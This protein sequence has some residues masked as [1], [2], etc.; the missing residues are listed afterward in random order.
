MAN[1]NQTGDDAAFLAEIRQRIDEENILRA[2]VDQ[3]NR[4]LNETLARLRNAEARS[5]LV[6]DE[7][8]SVQQ[9]YEETSNFVRVLQQRAAEADIVAQEAIRRATATGG[10]AAEQRAQQALLA[11]QQAQAR[12]AEAEARAES[13]AAQLD[14]L[15]QQFQ[16]NQTQSARSRQQVDELNREMATLREQLVALSRSI[17][18]STR[19]ATNLARNAV[20]STSRVPRGLFTELASVQAQ[21]NADALAY[22]LAYARNALLAGDGLLFLYEQGDYAAFKRLFSGWQPG[23]F[24]YGQ[25]W[26]AY[27]AFAALAAEAGAVRLQRILAET[28]P[29]GTQRAGVA[30]GASAFGGGNAAGNNNNNANNNNNNNNDFATYSSRLAD[31]YRSLWTDSAAMLQNAASWVLRGTFAGQTLPANAPPS[32]LEYQGTVS[33]ASKNQSTGT[34]VVPYNTSAVYKSLYRAIVL[35]FAFQQLFADGPANETP[36]DAYSRIRCGLLTYQPDRAGV[37]IDPR[38][39]IPGYMLVFSPPEGTLDDPAHRRAIVSDFLERWDIDADAWDDLGQVINGARAACNA[40]I[41][42]TNSGGARSTAVFHGGDR[43]PDSCNDPDLNDTPAANVAL[44]REVLDSPQAP[45]RSHQIDEPAEYANLAGGP[46]SSHWSSNAFA[47]APGETAAKQQADSATS[48][49][50]FERQVAGIAPF[51]IP[52]PDSAAASGY[53]CPFNAPLPEEES[54]AGNSYYAEPNYGFA[55]DVMML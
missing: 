3:L 24:G 33:V 49:Q 17:A 29:A 45:W 40:A 53:G 8:F 37:G 34:V 47:G 9:Q 55:E 1:P 51:I 12:L 44:F 54:T 35:R 28:A 27:A 2:R 6:A 46:P 7:E 22:N 11:A 39:P 4:Q 10:S 21:A 48:R 19:L 43:P 36:R 31:Q 30:S 15:R 25:E 14:A 52:Q 41:Y 23:D 13:A 18:E 38:D 5:N 16:E 32:V 42:I 26:V 20:S 50:I